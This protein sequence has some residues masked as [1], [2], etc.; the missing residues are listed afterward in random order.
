MFTVVLLPRCSFSSFFSSTSNS[1]AGHQSDKSNW[2]FFPLD[3]MDYI[4]SRFQVSGST[5]WDALVGALKK[6]YTFVYK[7][8]I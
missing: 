3:L 8:E 5:S 4:H 7:Y 1:S 2:I 6:K